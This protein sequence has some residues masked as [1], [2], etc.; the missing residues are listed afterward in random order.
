VIDA[1]GSSSFLITALGLGLMV[2]LIAVIT[3]RR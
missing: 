1:A 3:S 2:G